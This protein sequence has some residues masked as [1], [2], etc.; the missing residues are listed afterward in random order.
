MT[1]MVIV[2]LEKIN[3]QH[4]KP[5]RFFTPHGPIPFFIKSF[6][7]VPAVGN[8]RQA[9]QRGEFLQGKIGFG[10][11]CLTLFKGPECLVFLKLVNVSLGVVSDSGYHFNLIREFDHVIIGSET[12]CLTF[13]GC[14]I[15]CRQENDRDLRSIFVHP[16]VAHH[17]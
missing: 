12:E 6:V 4:K 15:F 10:Q 2:E 8:S 11:F 17:H 1:I 14:F 16:E 3:I 9:I 5:N 7:K 13:Y